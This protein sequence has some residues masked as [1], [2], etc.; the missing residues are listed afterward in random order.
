[1]ADRVKVDATEVVEF[2][3]SLKRMAK[4]LKNPRREISTAGKY[5]RQQIETR[6][7]NHGPND[8][9]RKWFPILALSAIQ[10]KNPPKMAMQL[11]KRD[12]QAGRTTRAK[13]ASTVPLAMASP[14]RTSS[15][16]TTELRVSP[17]K[18]VITPTRDTERY[19]QSSEITGFPSKGIMP[20]RSAFYFG[21]DN[22][23]RVLK[24]F[25]ERIDKEARRL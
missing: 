19:H 17:D 21:R 6:Y 8:D 23:K 11:A 15:A 25:G 18:A 12:I 7:R 16:A 14:L 1:M 10:R 4:R 24:I 5:M 20:N 22:L 3:K 9:G 13:G 2:Q